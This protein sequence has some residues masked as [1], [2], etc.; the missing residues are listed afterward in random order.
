MKD[1][2]YKMAKISRYDVYQRGV[3]NMAY[4][5]FDKKTGWKASVNEEPQS[6][7]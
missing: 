5:V 2:A 6:W 3:T 7:S 1:R 4:K